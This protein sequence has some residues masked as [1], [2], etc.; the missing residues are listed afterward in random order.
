MIRPVETGYSDELLADGSV[1]RTYEGGREEWRQRDPSRP[2]VV[3]WYDNASASGTDELLGDRIVKRVCDGTVT[4]GRDI[5]YGRTVW[6]RGETLMVNRTSFGGRMGLLLAG[7]GVT[8]LAVTEAQLPPLHLSPEEEEELRR[9]A[10][11]QPSGGGGDGA[12][13]SGSSGGDDWDGDWGGGDDGDWSDD[14]F[15]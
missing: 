12:G 4:Y 14:D 13:D 10:Q 8:A 3:R 7:V 2:G 5:G 11:E 1:H 6:G 9:Q 15:G